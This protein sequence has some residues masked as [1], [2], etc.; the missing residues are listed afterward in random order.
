MLSTQVNSAPDVFHI[1]VPFKNH[2]LDST[3]CYVI[4]DGGDTLIVD[5]GAYSEKSVAY[6]RQALEELDVDPVKAGYFLTHLHM[7]HAGLLDA[8]APPEA[9]VYLNEGDYR[10]ARPDHPELR[11]ADLE[12]ALVHE[13]VDAQEIHEMI[14][15]RRSRAGMFSSNHKMVFTEE[16]D[17]IPV[18]SYALQVVATPG[19]T[20]G[21][22]ALY[23]PSSGILFSGDHILF[24]LSPGVGL[25][26]PDGDSVA[27]YVQSLRKVQ[28]LRISHLCHSHGDLRDDFEERIEWLLNHSRE[29][30]AQVQGIVERNPGITGLEATKRIDFNVPFDCWEDISRVQRLSL[31]E[32]G[33]AFLRHLALTGAIRVEEDA[34]GVRRYFAE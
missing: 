18:G 22:Q 32:I 31:M 1:K 4:R 26:L 9:P 24:T 13:G 7:D 8:I 34:D 28:D 3:N 11:F 25:F 17:I 5:T 30:A 29:R 20:R 10:Q 2:K 21:H 14:S 33:A 23:E 19:H 15:K 6:L 12:E 27:A 16:G